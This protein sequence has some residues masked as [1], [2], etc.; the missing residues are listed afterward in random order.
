MHTKEQ[1][2]LS[3]FL[4]GKDIEDFKACG[5]TLAELEEL[6]QDFTNWA[7]ATAEFEW[8][9]HEQQNQADESIQLF[10]GHPY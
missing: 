2:T 1:N 7:D 5:G 8:R 6:K 9:R 3:N 4:T 10:T